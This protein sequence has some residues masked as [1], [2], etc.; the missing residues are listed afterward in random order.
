MQLSWIVHGGVGGSSSEML[1][2]DVFNSHLQILQLD[3]I[4]ATNAVPVSIVEVGVDNVDF[5]SLNIFM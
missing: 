5:F 4:Q 3:L 1:H 2:Y